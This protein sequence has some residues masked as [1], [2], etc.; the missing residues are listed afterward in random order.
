MLLNDQPT[1]LMSA[2]GTPKSLVSCMNERFDR[3][4]CELPRNSM[5]VLNSVKKAE[6]N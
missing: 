6:K 1:P 4:R 5:P 3:R 2:L